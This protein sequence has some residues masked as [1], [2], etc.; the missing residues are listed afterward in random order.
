MYAETM[1]EHAEKGAKA[2]RGRGGIHYE[3][4][5]LGNKLRVHAS[6]QTKESITF[7]TLTDTLQMTLA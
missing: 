6:I 3:L 5:I 4:L 1:R 2:R 7:L